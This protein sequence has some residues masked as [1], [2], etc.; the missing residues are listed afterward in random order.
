MV[1]ILHEPDNSQHN[2]PSVTLTLSQ[3]KMAEVLRIGRQVFVERGFRGTTMGA[4]AAAA[5]VSKRTLY[6][7][8]EDK[9]A[10]FRACVIEGARLFPLP[11]FEQGDDLHETLRRYASSILAEASKPSALGMGR[12]LTREQTDFPEILPIAANTQEQYLVQPLAG[13]LRHN[14]L[15]GEDATERARLFISMTLAPV[16]DRL[17]VGTGRLDR[18][19][20]D[21]HAQLVA[22]IFLQG[23]V[24]EGNEGVSHDDRKVE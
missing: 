16:H 13:W 10:L 21:R 23:V 8:H 7:W 11:R 2:S 18:K 1:I 19:S 24:V 6:L 22:T 3:R 15:E 9:S 4:I 20:I 12:L 14:G 5:G 17:L